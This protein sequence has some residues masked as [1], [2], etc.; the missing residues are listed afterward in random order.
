MIQ[1]LSLNM[2]S[3]G[4]YKSDVTDQMIQLAISDSISRDPIKRRSLYF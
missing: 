1:W 3:L 4:Q 2:I